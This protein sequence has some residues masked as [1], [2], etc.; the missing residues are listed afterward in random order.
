[1]DD[2]RSGFKKEGGGTS[3]SLENLQEYHQAWQCLAL[4][5]CF[6]TDPGNQASK[7]KWFL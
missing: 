7:T 1:M 5:F 4:A 6:N 3:H 2:F